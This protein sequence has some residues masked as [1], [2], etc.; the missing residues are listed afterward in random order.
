VISY[1]I[2]KIIE[3]FNKKDK[4]NELLCQDRK[5]ERIECV[6]STL[7]ALEGA[8]KGIRWHYL[9]CET[10]EELKSFFESFK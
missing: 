5:G 4:S 9:D 10:K 1:T 3:I 2:C 7:C 8:V 6:F